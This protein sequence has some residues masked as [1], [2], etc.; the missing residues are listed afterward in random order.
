MSSSA[1]ESLSL[2]PRLARCMIFIPSRMRSRSLYSHSLGQAKWKGT[3]L[4]SGYYDRIGP[5]EVELDAQISASQMPKI[6]GT[7]EDAD[8]PDNDEWEVPTPR[9]HALTPSTPA[10]ASPALANTSLS[11]KKFVMPAVSSFYSKAPPKPK[12]N[13]PLYDFSWPCLL[14]TVNSSLQTRSRG[15]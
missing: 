13:G 11:A 1:K 14:N 9:V 2:C 6:V 4:S 3:P 8:V 15:R 7:S 5:R 10:P 12:A